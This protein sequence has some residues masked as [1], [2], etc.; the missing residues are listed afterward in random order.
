MKGIIIGFRPYR[1]APEGSDRVYSGFSVCVER[2]HAQAPEGHLGEM[3]DCFSVAEGA[4]GSYVPSIGDAV[5]YHLYRENGRQKCGFLMLD[6]E[7]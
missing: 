5:Q 7:G 3:V 2:D 4:T 1:Y 6:P